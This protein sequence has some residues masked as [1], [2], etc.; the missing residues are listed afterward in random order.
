MIRRITNAIKSLFP[1]IH[2]VRKARMCADQYKSYL[3]ELKYEN[4][5]IDGE[6]TYLKLWS[7]L[8]ARVEPYSYRLFS[9][10]MGKV[11]H[12]IPDYIGTEILSY[13]LNPRRYS[14]FYEDKNTY[15]SYVLLEHALPKTYLKRIGG[16]KILHEDSV[17]GIEIISSPTLCLQNLGVEMFILKPTVDTC[18]GKG[19]LMFKKQNERY[20]SSKGI[21]FSDEFLNEYGDDYVIQEVIEQH[22]DLAKF[23]P[24][25][26]NTLRICT[27]RSVNDESVTVTGALIRI[28][29]SGEVVDNAHAGGCFV[30]IDLE[31]GNLLHYACDQY[32]NKYETW[33]GVSFS[34][35]HIIPH[36]NKVKEFAE[37]IASYNKHSRLLALDL[38]VDK[39][40]IPRVI[41]INIDG[42][43]YWLFQF[44]GQDVF[45]GEVQS[46][47]DYCNKKLLMDG[48]KKLV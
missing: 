12:I 34:E 22:P 21:L 17:E 43:S 45:N 16:G 41:E 15:S 13:Y 1:T 31:S 32:G 6:D 33:N 9:H 48:R 42:F 8:T 38:T 30:G 37:K 14:D 27:Y 29:K 20:V 44:C 36:W 24:T 4:K 5:S 7:Q 28:G 18:S 40:G 19:V 25:S 46:V 3:Q 2:Y 47:I 11:P 10:Y 39:L 26:V 23:N 35:N